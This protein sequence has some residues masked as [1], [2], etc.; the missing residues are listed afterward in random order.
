MEIF[1]I[2]NS[3]FVFFGHHSGKEFSFTDGI[4][5]VFIESDEISG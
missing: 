3:V 2:T 4:V 5:I 1:T